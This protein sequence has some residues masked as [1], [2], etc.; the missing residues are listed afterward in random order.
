[1]SGSLHKKFRPNLK[2]TDGKN[3]E[4]IHLTWDELIRVYN[5][6]FD[7]SKDYISQ[8]RDV[9]CFCCFTGLRYSD[10]ASLKK[11]DVKENYISVVM[12]KTSSAIKYRVEQIHLHDTRKICKCRF[13][14]QQGASRNK[15]S[16]NE[17]LS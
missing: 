17:Q 13:A 12:Q 9:F 11:S 4:I 6:S 5:Y 7:S 16:K 1:Y 8:T 10:A 3:R 14:R 2:G 15:Q